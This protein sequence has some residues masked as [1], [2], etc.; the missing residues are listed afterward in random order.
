MGKR[1]NAKSSSREPSKK[2]VKAETARSEDVRTPRQDKKAEH[3]NQMHVRRGRQLDRVFPDLPDTQ[4]SLHELVFLGKTKSLKF[5]LEKLILEKT[6]DDRPLNKNKVNELRCTLAFGLACY[7]P[8]R[9]ASSDGVR[10]EEISQATKLVL[11]KNNGIRSN[12]LL[13][14][15]LQNDP[16][17][18]VV[19]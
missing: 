11:H 19:K 9:S 6:D 18:E 7:A 1:A 15:H 4:N 13:C 8:L 17:T 2:V 10:S 3:A 16:Y 12:L 5:E 14:R